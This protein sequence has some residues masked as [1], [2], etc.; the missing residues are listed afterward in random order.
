MTD[1]D[2]AGIVAVVV[3]QHR[4]LFGSDDRRRGLLYYICVALNAEEAAEL[5]GVLEKGDRG[6]FVPSDVAVYRPT[7]EHFDVLAGD[8]DRPTWQPLGVITN[9]TWMWKRATIALFEP[10]TEPREPEP[11]PDEPA[12]PSVPPP[13]PR[14]G[15]HEEQLERFL[16]AL[17]SFVDGFAGLAGVHRD[18]TRAIDRLTDEG[19]RELASAIRELAV[20]VKTARTVGIRFRWV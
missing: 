16:D 1:R 3:E 10:G 12:D 18:E 11:E 8:P 14:P 17:E 2:N 9:P 20:E 19:A 13:L 6:G 7:M 5:W 4:D 15:E